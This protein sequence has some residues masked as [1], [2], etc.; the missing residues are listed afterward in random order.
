MI[1]VDLSMTMTAAVPRPDC[2]SFRASKSILRVRHRGRGGLG[3]YRTSSQIRLGRT[4][5]EQPPGMM[6]RRLS[7]PP[8]TPPQCRSI[9]S[10]NGI[11]ISSVVSCVPIGEWGGNPRL[12]RGC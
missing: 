11:D 10:F 5:T 8:R 2:T 7:H 6:P 3:V 12:C 1:S 9:K 4:G